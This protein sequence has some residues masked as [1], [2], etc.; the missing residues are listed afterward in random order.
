MK[1]FLATMLVLMALSGCKSASDAAKEQADAVAY[2][3]VEYANASVPGPQIVV[4]PG[5]I[6]AS[7]A[8]FTQKVSE[9]NIADFAEIELSKANF[10]VL[11]RSDIGP[12]IN[13]IQV[14]VG[15][16]DPDSLKKFRKGRFQTTRWFLRFDILKAEPVAAAQ[17]K[18]DGTTLGIIAGALIAGATDSK[19]AG[20][21]AGAAIASAK[22]SDAS[23]VWLVGLRYKILD[24]VTGEQ[25]A[26]GYFEEKMEIGEKVTSFLGITQAKG[27]RVGLDTMSQLLVQKAVQEIDSQYKGDQ[28]PPVVQASAAAPE[29]DEEPAAQTGKAQPE[30]AAQA[31]PAKPAHQPAKAAHAKA[32]SHQASGTI[33]ATESGGLRMDAETYAKLQQSL[34]EQAAQEGK[35]AE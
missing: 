30:K 23:E 29:T 3:P 20:T 32:G 6:K 19:A 24:A 8:T 28:P 25:A 35:P 5:S 18:F 31:E 1:R 2:K 34:K 17:K 22:S 4:L 9:N 7:G 26:T 21:A 33:E 13:E 11:E 15:M 16:G 14:A 10:K 12:L 27:V